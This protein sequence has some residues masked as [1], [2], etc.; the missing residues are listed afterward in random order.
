MNGIE[1]AIDRAG[2]RRPLARVLG[3]TEQAIYQWVVRGWVP[4]ARAAQIT[5]LY[6][7]DMGKLLKPE[8]AKIMG[9]KPRPQKVADGA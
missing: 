7:I 1:R 2:G 3:V 6:G 4:P 8:L 5:K 9:A